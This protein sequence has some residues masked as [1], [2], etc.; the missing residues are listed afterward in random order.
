MSK[1]LSFENFHEKLVVKQLVKSCYNCEHFDK[2]DLG[3]SETC[4]IWSVRPPAKV[5]VFGC[6]DW[7]GEIPF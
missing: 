7:E 3:G 1:P 5:I 2:E 6:A 4:V